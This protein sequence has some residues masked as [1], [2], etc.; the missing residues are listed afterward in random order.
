M[1]VENVYI[2]ESSPYKYL[3]RL[4]I[5]TLRDC[6]EMGT[7][8]NCRSVYFYSI[9]GRQSDIKTYNLCALSATL[10]ES[11]PKQH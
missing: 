3:L 10:L 4:I 1:E 8:T 11:I 5:S 2:L 7:H 6:W 9:S